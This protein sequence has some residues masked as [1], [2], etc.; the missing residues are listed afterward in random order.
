MSD[1][2]MQHERVTNTNPPIQTIAFIILVRIVMYLKRSGM[3]KDP[4]EIKLKEIN[5]KYVLK[6]NLI[7]DFYYWTIN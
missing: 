6:T 7:C 1:S 2:Q 4:R 3:G 5:S